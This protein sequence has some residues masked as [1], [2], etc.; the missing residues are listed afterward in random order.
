[1]KRQ[2]IVVAFF[3]A[4]GLSNNLSADVISIDF[5]YFPGPDGILGSGDDIPTQPDDLVLD[6]YASANVRFLPG[7]PGTLYNMIGGLPGDHSM[8]STGPRS[9][10]L[11]RGE[12]ILPVS[13]IS[14]RIFFGDSFGNDFLR[15]L[16]QD[17]TVIAQVIPT[18]Y[19]ELVSISAD[20]PIYG[21]VIDGR[22]LGPP[23]ATLNDLSFNVIPTL[24]TGV[25]G[26][27][28]LGVPARRRR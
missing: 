1:M 2:S 25:L 11:I 21:F 10:G 19:D 5:E 14:A 20:E 24:S 8:Y 3:L 9:E 16:R 22:D 4:A 28:V 12:F 26:V 27:L 17:G 7:A 15:A 13:S 18:F 6:Q 23:F